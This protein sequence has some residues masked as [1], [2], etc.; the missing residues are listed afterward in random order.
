MLKNLS[1]KK[2]LFKSKKAFTLLEMVAVIF[3]IA[4]L[5]IIFLPNI[6]AQRNHASSRVDAAFEKTIQTQV[7]IYTEDNDVANLKVDPWQK[8]KEAQLLNES[9][10]KQAVEKGY[11]IDANGQVNLPKKE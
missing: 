1:I 6:N 2:E 8:L 11:T 3:I 10:R 7:D 4:L 9:Q 5:L